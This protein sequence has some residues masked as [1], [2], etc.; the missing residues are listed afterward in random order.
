MP[1]TNWQIARHT[2]A[3]FSIQSL[4]WPAPTSLSRLES[5]FNPL[6]RKLA[7]VGRNRCHIKTRRSVNPLRRQ[8]MGGGMDQ[9]SLFAVANA[10]QRPAE[11]LAGTKAHFHKDDLAAVAHDEVDFTAP[12]T[13]VPL[14][15]CQALGLKI[16]QG[17]VFGPLPRSQVIGLWLVAE[18]HLRR[19]RHGA[20]LECRGDAPRLQRVA[21]KLCAVELSVQLIASQRQYA[22][23]T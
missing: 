11:A 2:Y 16:G 19:C 15:Q 1:A 21:L 20:R 4:A 10:G 9:P 6:Y 22:G 14:H 5:V 18:Q 13:V 7:L 12:A 23:G 8:V 17:T 3:P